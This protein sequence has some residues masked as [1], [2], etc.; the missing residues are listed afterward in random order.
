MFL[1]LYVKQV[2]LDHFQ[3]AQYLQQKVNKITRL[4]PRNLELGVVLYLGGKRFFLVV[5]VFSLFFFG[6]E[7]VVARQFGEL[8]L[9]NDF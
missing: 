1:V 7:G 3:A 8:W 5:V 4:D 9:G 6:G 2:I